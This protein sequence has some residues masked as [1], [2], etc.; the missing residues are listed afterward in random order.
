MR[1]TMSYVSLDCAL[2]NLEN[3]NRFPIEIRGIVNAT[4]CIG[5]GKRVSC[6]DRLEGKSKYA[7]SKHTAVHSK[8]V[9]APL[10]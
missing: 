5:I 1:G 7:I 8:I 3:R 2:H 6:D 4:C 10:L 9:Q